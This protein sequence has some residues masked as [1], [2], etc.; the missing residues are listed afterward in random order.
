MAGAGF[1]VDLDQRRRTQLDVHIGAFATGWAS[2]TP[3]IVRYARSRPLRR[4][5]GL[6][7]NI[8]HTVSYTELS[9]T[10]FKGF[11]S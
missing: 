7:P 3:G 8:P 9:L 5:E 10:Q 6:R 4:F 1:L 11:W 2:G